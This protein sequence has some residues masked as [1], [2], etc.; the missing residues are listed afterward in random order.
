MAKN[1]S[2]TSALD[3]I[4]FIAFLIRKVYL[5]IVFCIVFALL[6]V[7]F[8][9][10]S[11]HSEETRAK[12][13]S[14]LAEYNASVS[15][16][17]DSIK[18]METRRNIINETMKEDPI[19]DMYYSDVTYSC[20]ISFFLDSEDSIIV[21]DTGN[22]VYPIQERLVSYYD[23]FNLS[24]LLNST[25]RNDYLEEMIL[26]T[27]KKNHC[28][29][30][31]YNKNK[32]EAERWADAV[33]NELY[34]YAV[35][36]NNWE[37]NGKTIN[38]SQYAGQYYV[39]VVSKYSTSVIELDKNLNEQAQSLEKLEA[40]P[41]RLYRFLRYG[42]IGFI[43]GGFLSVLVILLLFAIKNPITKS[44]VAEKISGIHFWGS[45]YEENGILGRIA[46]RIIGERKFSS[47]KEAIEFLRGNIR[48]TSLKDGA[49]KNMAILCS[50]KSRFVQKQAKSLESV[51]SEFGCKS[52]LVTDVSVNPESAD[53]VSSTDAV[54]LLERQWVSQW[55][56][57]GVSMDLAE[58]FNKP[59][60]GFVLC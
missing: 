27:A 13:E 53:V 59:V 28:L 38:S 51:L 22:M 36:E 31:V 15:N 29:I 54:I 39:D 25:I 46:R 49:I 24:S 44:F 30:T 3:I 48:N 52:T 23:S 21:T 56:L 57:V 34:K 32:E 37:F 41:P 35:T 12:Y 33:Y 2:T 60:V 47:E 55:K 18:V 8:N 45:L 1:P 58:R 50:C 42:A 6:G 43:I 4:D 11:A 19:Y 7:G 16:T 9:I 40:K 14:E 10:L 26:F 5:V 20:S 17:K